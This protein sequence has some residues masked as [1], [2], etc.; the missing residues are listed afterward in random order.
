MPD[1][2]KWMIF[3]ANGYIVR[4]DGHPHLPHARPDPALSVPPHRAWGFLCRIVECGCRLRAC[5][6]FAPRG[7]PLTLRLRGKVCTAPN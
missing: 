4:C 7:G 1:R 5:W 3:G 2:A 6:V